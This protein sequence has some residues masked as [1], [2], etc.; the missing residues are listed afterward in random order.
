MSG[1][2]HATITISQDEYRRLHEL[3]MER[4]FKSKKK[5]KQTQDPEEDKEDLFPPCSSLSSLTLEHL[6]SF[7]LTREAILRLKNV[8]QTLSRMRS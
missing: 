5:S 6:N 3:D 1:H 7:P 4:R 2:K 8:L